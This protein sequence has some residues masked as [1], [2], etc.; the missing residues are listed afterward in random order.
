MKILPLALGL[1][2]VLSACGES[3]QRLNERPT[4]IHRRDTVPFGEAL[5]APS[6]AT[7]AQSDRVDALEKLFIDGRDGECRKQLARFFA[8]GGDHPRAHDLNGRL[9]ILEG[10]YAEA[11]DAFGRAV[12]GSPRWLQPRLAQAEC[13][14]EL[15]RP[16]AAASVY[17]E[18]D[19]LMPDAPWGPWGMGLIAAQGKDS[20]RSIALLDEAL[21][22]DPEH[23]PSLLARAGMAERAGDTVRE[24]ALLLHAS[25]LD[26][27]NAQTWLRLAALTEADNR[28]VD[29]E[30][31]LARAFALTRD[32]R[33]RERLAQLCDRRGDSAAAARWRTPSHP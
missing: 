1:V 14:L 17:A 13:F 32:P 11:A 4:W 6:A 33:L 12:A 19:R 23:V 22:R 30:T 5:P 28:L 15:K 2:L 27:D 7:I 31:H 21:R 26:P 18:L 25:G 16:Q 9:L 20:D 29:A 3:Q 24:E 8:E 10:K